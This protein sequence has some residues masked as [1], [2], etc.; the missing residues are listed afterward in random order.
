[1]SISFA[2][3]ATLW[4]LLLV[5]LAL[6]LALAGRA[7]MPR[8]RRIASLGLRGLILTLLVLAA[9]GAQIRRPVDQL[10][11][12]F[13]VDASDSVSPAARQQATE[14]IRGAV[15]RM[16]RGDEAAVVVF[17]K[18]A[19][20]E[21]TASAARTLPDLASVPIA[22]RT[23]I[24]EAI[25]LGL[26]L[27]PA[28]RQ[29]RLVL[30]SDGQ[31]NEGDAR[32]AAELAAARGVTLDVVAVGGAPA[33][34]EV[35]L[36]Q[37]QAPSPVR[38]GQ[39]FELAVVIESNTATTARLQ[40]FG[41]EALI[42]DQ[43]VALQAGQTTV[44]VPVQAEEA[45]F[46]RYR[47]VVTAPE[48]VRPENNEAAAFALVQ[49]PPR[50]LLV[51]DPAT[52]TEA[53]PLAQAL[54][55]A[56]MQ[57]ETV[58]PG[59]MPQELT[60]LAVYDSVV[61]VN[62]TAENVPP[63][64]ME[65]LPPFVRDLGR[66]LVMVGGPQSFGAGGWLRTPV[67]EALPV[68][69]EVRPR[70]Q[71]ANIAL[72]LAVDKS[73]SMGRCHCDDPNNPQQQAQRLE[74]GLPKVEIAKDAVLQASF[75]LGQMD[76]IGVVAFDAAA[77]W[78]LRPA[79]YPGEAAIEQAIAPIEANGQTNIFAGLDAAEGSLREVPARVKHVIL[80]TDGWSRA[81]DYQALAERM[82]A[83]GITLSVVAAGRG[84]ASMDL[85][86]LAEMG[87]GRF[88]EAADIGQ[89]PEI[90]L[91]E[92]IR[93]VGR[94]V[95]EEPF[96][97]APASPSR[98]LQGFDPGRLPVLVGY[99]GAT[100]KP[101]ATVALLTP[102]QD[103]L[104]AQ[105]RYGLG[106]AVA[107]TSDLSGRWAGDWVAWSEFGD[108]AAQLVGW[109]LPDPQSPTLDVEAR[110]EGGDAVI[111]ATATDE[112]GRPRNFLE[113]SVQLIGPDLDTTTADLP[114]TA[115][116]QYE[117]RLPL[118]TVGAYLVTVTQRG[119]DGQPEAGATLGLVVPYSP[120]YRLLAP[121]T[122]LLE[123][124][125][126]IGDGRTLEATPEAAAAVFEHPEQ[127]V[128]R[129]TDLWPLL[130]VLAALLFPFD[131][132]ARRLLLTAGD[133]ARL[134]AA[135]APRRLRPQ[136]AP[137]VPV[138]DQ[139]LFEAKRRVERRRSGAAEESGSGGAEEQ[140][141]GG[142]GE[143]RSGATSP[144]AVPPSSPGSAPASPRPGEGGSDE[145]TLA[146]LRRAKEERRRR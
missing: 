131:V 97:P 64:T 121:D 86:G 45:G 48:D 36:S 41:D 85:Q 43:E 100:P 123:Q 136:P 107:W 11:V 65:L 71:E 73:G 83:E 138:L 5:P 46:R 50:V 24:A 60:E 132:A 145:D 16:P 23:D 130:L 82:A 137:A 8:G 25:Q 103:P 63:A 72:V 69:M 38:Q 113:T 89:V 35:L 141:S 91:K 128:T 99:N 81:G 18:D 57:V 96:R 115:A 114:Q 90:F 92:T 140:G 29:K 12:A 133:L 39:Q 144:P 117:V 7:R 55:A 14:F 56:R 108:F 31:P 44:A 61:L 120:E 22:T 84:S 126:R 30:L 124:L 88:Y 26:A 106:R 47:A 112:E 93:A 62:V 27:L 33:G 32:Q 119:A 34:P 28:D 10:A 37:V 105:W 66:G 80:L 135:L 143:R 68:D 87:G 118:D 78:A 76:F 127:P 13:L 52:P 51:A 58:A 4:L 20:V 40:I 111:R 49:G 139:S 122:A 21:R 102:R 134:R 2:Y 101:A 53:Q 75:A 67:E 104:L 98:I 6:G 42:Y 109:T 1:M 59:S 19:L 146:R 129:S 95:I 110:I 70:E 74:S 142:A 15:E 77:H 54:E 116:G 94:Y 3:P 9:A 125:A 17:G 79:L